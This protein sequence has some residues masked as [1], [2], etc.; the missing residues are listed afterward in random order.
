VTWGRLALVA[1]CGDAALRIAAPK[2]RSIYSSGGA[3]EPW[4]VNWVIQD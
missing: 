2:G 1:N 4:S 3:G